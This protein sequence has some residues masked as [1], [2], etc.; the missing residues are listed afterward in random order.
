MITRTPQLED[1]SD[2]AALIDAQES[3]LDPG[4][5]RAPES[6]PRD[7]LRGHFPNPRNQVWCD[8][9]GAIQAWAS[10]QPDPH[11]K[12]LEVEIFRR[13]GYSDLAE[14]WQWCVDQGATEFPDFVL[15]PTT[16]SRDEEMAALLSS[17]GF[18]LLR[19]YH[20]LTRPLHGETPPPLPSECTIEVMRSEA[21]DRAWHTAHQ[22][23]FSRHFGFTPRPYEAWIALMRDQES[24]DP[25]GR[26]LLRVDGQVA[27]FVVCGLDNAHENG[28]YIAL[29]GVTHGYQGRGYGEL[30]LR[31]ALSHSAGKGF[32]D[33]DLVVDTGNSSGAI[34]LY[35]KVGFTT[36]SEFHLYAQSSSI[37]L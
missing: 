25:N 21:D 1:A 17:S 29:L 34:A 35:E 6:W 16:N 36:L 3:A 31:W 27:G 8:D 4:H 30:L 18:E 5:K 26:F 33:V 23:A 32:T 37:S 19:R 14:V 9:A 11:R 15:W 13:P 7:L 2:L 28:G 10:C 22:D 24:A 12:R 20:M